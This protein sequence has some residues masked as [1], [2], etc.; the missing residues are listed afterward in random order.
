MNILDINKL[1]NN[2]YIV[3]LP[4]IDVDIKDGVEY[5]FKNVFYLDY[6]LTKEHAKVLIEHVNN[7]AKGLILFS[8]DPFYRLVLPY[9]KKKKQLSLI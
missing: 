8:Y 5:T 4:K 1:K 3:L 7:K 9:I 6:E 2:D